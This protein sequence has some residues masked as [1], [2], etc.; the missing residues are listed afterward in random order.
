M[1]EAWNSSR[2]KALKAYR[3][4]IDRCLRLL[5]DGGILLVASCSQAIGAEDMRKILEQQGKK[6]QVHL[7]VIAETGHPADHVWPVSF[8]TGRYL[9]AIAVE[10]RGAW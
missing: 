5:D 6:A 10:R 7:D 4:L 2:D 9:S 8:T 1:G 3:Y